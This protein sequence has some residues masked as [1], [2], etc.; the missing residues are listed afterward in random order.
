MKQIKIYDLLPLL[1]PG[2]V[3]MDADC[4]W[5][6]YDAKP[7]VNAVEPP[8]DWYGVGHD[9]VPLSD[10]FNIAPFDGDWKDSLMECGE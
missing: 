5:W 2:W 8:M 4:T 3:A 10:S 7:N 1:R 9:S 6:R